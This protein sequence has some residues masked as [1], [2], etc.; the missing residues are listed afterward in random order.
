MTEHNDHA[1]V[2][3][4]PPF[5]VLIH[6]LGAFLLNWRLPLQFTSVKYIP[7]IG[8]GLVV[9]GFGAA[10]S[11][12]SQFRKMKTTV[13]PH[14]SVNVIVTNGPYRFSRNP[15]YLGFVFILIG[16]PLALN[17]YWGLV[18]S[19]FL[20]LFMNRLVIQHEEAYLE[21]KFGDEYKRYKS[22]VRRWL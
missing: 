9:L 5:L 3:I 21:R 22:L 1:E 14:G 20:V 13:N 6:I 8:Y 7:W 4:S 2:K 15:I 10:F 18:L 12:I 19:P 11:A 17:N 16:L